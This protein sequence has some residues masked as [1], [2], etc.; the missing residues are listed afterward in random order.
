MY[1]IF[2][3]LLMYQKICPIHQLSNFPT[4]YFSHRTVPIFSQDNLIDLLFAKTPSSLLFFHLPIININICD[5]T[6]IY[7]SASR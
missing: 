1:I 3:I 5:I 2:D 6:I 7:D 4:V